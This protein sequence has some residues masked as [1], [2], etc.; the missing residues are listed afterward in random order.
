VATATLGVLSAGVAVS[1]AATPAT[2]KCATVTIAP[3]PNSLLGLDVKAI[4][5]SKGRCVQF[6]NDTLSTA[7]VDVKGTKYRESIPTKQTTSGKANYTVTSTVTVEA[8]SGIRSGNS[9]IT[10]AAASPSPS[11][12]ATVSPTTSPTAKASSKPTASTKAKHKKRKKKAA[13]L[14]LPSLPPLPAGGT[15]N[16]AVP[17][18]SNP[19]VAPGETS[20]SSVPV[21]G[22]QSV[23]AAVTTLEPVGTASKRG[24]P[25]LVAAVVLIGLI[26]GYGRVVLAAVPNSARSRD[27]RRHQA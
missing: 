16:L 24:L 5:V 14:V 15:A 26:C 12:S 7:V 8:M 3:K 13:K 21:S 18:P 6:T 27:K 2:A 11:A 25:V 20:A 1:A 19:L 17:V 9:T 4:T 23:P 22:T 10:V